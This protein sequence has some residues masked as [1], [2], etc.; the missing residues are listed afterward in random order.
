M[1]SIMVILSGFGVFDDGS[2]IHESVLTMSVLS[3]K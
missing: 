2:E 1:K 3:Q